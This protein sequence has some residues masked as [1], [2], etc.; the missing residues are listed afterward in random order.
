MEDLPDNLSRS[1]KSIP[2][3]YNEPLIQ[4][5]KRGWLGNDTNP[6]ILTIPKRTFIKRN[7]YGTCLIQ[8]HNKPVL[9][10]IK[11]YKSSFLNK[12]KYEELQFGEEKPYNHFN[13]DNIGRCNIP[14]HKSNE[15]INQSRSVSRTLSGFEFV[16]YEIQD[17]DAIHRNIEL[18][19]QCDINGRLLSLQ[20]QSLFTKH[21]SLP[22]YKKTLDQWCAD[23]IAP[24]FTKAQYI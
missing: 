4:S 21:L 8:I 3:G 9:L 7:E 11:R 12:K 18:V 24:T 20:S 19:V 13:K 5:I 6:T 10:L 15:K 16:A 1:I 23:H 2:N 22:E 14:Y 17:N